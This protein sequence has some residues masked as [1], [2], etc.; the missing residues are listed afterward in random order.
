M[1]TTLWSVDLSSPRLR[2]FC[3]SDP[4]GQGTVVHEVVDASVRVRVDALRDDQ[5]GP[6]LGGERGLDAEDDQSG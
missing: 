2:P 3:R 5:G 4:A 1:R 6:L